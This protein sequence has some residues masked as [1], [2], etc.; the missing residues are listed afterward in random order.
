VSKIHKV[1]GYT[2]QAMSASCG[3]IFTDSQMCFLL[4]K[5]SGAARLNGSV[6]PFKNAPLSRNFFVFSGGAAP[7]ATPRKIDM[8]VAQSLRS[9]RPHHSYR[10][11]FP[12][13]PPFSPKGKGS[14]ELNP[15]IDF[16]VT[17]CK[18]L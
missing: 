16:C 2:L 8:T 13:C 11:F 18:T 17:F 6:D 10:F 14:G 9:L 4:V 7:N 3:A 1:R 5:N 12:L 15:A